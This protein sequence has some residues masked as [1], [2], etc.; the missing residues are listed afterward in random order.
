MHKVLAFPLFN[1]DLTVSLGMVIVLWYLER[2][3][4]PHQEIIP[5]STGEISLNAGGIFFDAGELSYVV[6][7][8]PYNKE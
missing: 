1:H 3:L 4:I 5:K 2:V 7:R 8:C 6:W